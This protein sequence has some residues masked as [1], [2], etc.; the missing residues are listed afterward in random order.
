M[1]TARGDPIPPG[2]DTARATYWPGLDG[3]RGLAILMVFGFHLPIGAFRAGSYGVIVFFVLSGFLITTILLRE[4]DAH[5][6]IDLRR[7]FLRR[8]R[9]LF[10]ALIVVVAAHLVLQFTILGEPEHWWERSWPV[11]A[12]VS[13]YVQSAG[14]QLVHMAH[15]WSLAIEEHFYLLWPVTLIV[16]P[17]RW[18]F[19]VTCALF[20]AFAAWRLSLLTGGAPHDRIYFATDTNAF[21]PLLGC[22]LAIGVHEK[23]IPVASSNVCSLSTAALL[24]AAC[25]PWHYYDRRLLYFAVPISVLAATAVYGAVSGPPDW[26]HHPVLVWFGTIS[27]GLYLWHYM[28]ISLPWENLRPVPPLFSMIMAPIALAWLSWH[29]IEAPLIRR[30]PADRT[31]VQSS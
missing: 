28:M 20:V 9:R 24:L 16:L 1:L 22:A 30:R 4:L 7:F 23:R 5:D 31:A 27:Y 15:T 21:A 13:N 18:R 10:P 25:I 6:R 19:P 17:R 3:L 14:A 11:L 2:E 8:A 26:L 12:Y 29:F